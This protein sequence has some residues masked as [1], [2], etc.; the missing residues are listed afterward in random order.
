ML[1]SASTAVHVHD[2]KNPEP[3]L[4]F[5]QHAG[6]VNAVK[7]TYNARIIASAGDDSKLVL[8]NAATGTQLGLLEPIDTRPA[9]LQALAFTTKSDFIASGGSDRKVR[10]WDLKKKELTSCFNSHSGAVLSLAWNY[11][12]S[13]L[14]SS[15]ASGEIMLHSIISGVAVA[16]FRPRDSLGI[17][18]ICFSPFRRQ[19]IAAGA[20]TGSLYLWDTNSR[21]LAST[22]TEV[23]NSPISS[24]AFSPVNHLL[25]CS[26][27]LDQRIQ[28]YDSN[29]RKVV[30]TIDTEGPLTSLAFN[31]DGHTIAAGTLYG[32]VYIYDLRGG[33]NFKMSLNGHVGNSVNSLEFSKPYESSS[34]KRETTNRFKTIDEIRMEAKARHEQKRMSRGSAESYDEKPA[35]V[36]SSASSTPN[37]ASTSVPRTAWAADTE[38][39]NLSRGSS[40]AEPTVPA[41]PQIVPQFGPPQK[42][43]SA[44]TPVVPQV[45]PPQLVPQVLVQSTHH[46]TSVSQPPVASTP[47][48][49]PAPSQ[50][51]SVVSSIDTPLAQPPPASNQSFASEVSS[52]FSQPSRFSEEQEEAIATM[53]ESVL[54]TSNTTVRNELS[55]LHIDL[56]RQFTIQQTELSALIQ[57]YISDNSSLRKEVARM[58]QEVA[59]LKNRK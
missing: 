33:V 50:P 16:T 13:H 35:S 30:K 43:A 34:S 22:F 40:R 21:N 4:S 20:E 31:S 27:G 58:E 54:A 39:P 44:P 2:I 8:S 26:A 14:A 12:D 11:V 25:L 38:P 17:K 7:W 52:S 55:N 24:V 47:L 10:V 18:S 1:V 15:S 19:I 59:R 37:P 29:D 51:P 48:R 42:V 28:F 6:K 56:I 57:R 36:S 9:P 53:I 3:Q 49:T 32:A 23:H 45:V 46:R 41:P 5:S